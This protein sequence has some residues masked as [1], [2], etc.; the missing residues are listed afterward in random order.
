MKILIADVESITNFYGFY[1]L[2]M[3]LRAPMLVTNRS[4][5]R[6]I[7]PPTLP[8]NIVPMAKAS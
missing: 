1:A 5:H 7:R 2:K 8:G 3:P 6:N 4:V